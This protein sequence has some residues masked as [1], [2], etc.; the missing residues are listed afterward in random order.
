M[1]LHITGVNIQNRNLWFVTATIKKA[2]LPLQV[3]KG[4]QRKNRNLLVLRTGFQ[5]IEP[6]NFHFI[7]IN[8]S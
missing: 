2:E 3:F 8:L 5:Q 4:D 7:P 6:K 1:I